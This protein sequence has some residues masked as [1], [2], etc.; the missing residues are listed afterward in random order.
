MKKIVLM[1]FT[2]MVGFIFSYNVFAQDETAPDFTLP[3]LDGK[4]FSLKDYLGKKTIVLNF[5]AAWCSSC[6]E[7][8]PLL[9]SLKKK[10]GAQGEVVFVGVNAGDSERAAKKF[11]DRLDYSYQIVMDKNK[12]IAKA[13][14]VAGLP[15][16]IV[17]SKEGKITFRGSRPPGSL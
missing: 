12:A 16:T 1:L 5:W 15:Q 2:V 9:L 4:V 14:H 17:I 8:M 11:V 6:E 13:Y 3:T 7:E 10:Y